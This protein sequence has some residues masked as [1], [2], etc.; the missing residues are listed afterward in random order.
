MCMHSSY[1]TPIYNI[2]ILEPSTRVPWFRLS[3]YL[4]SSRGIYLSR[5]GYE[6]MCAVLCHVLDRLEH[7]WLRLIRPHLSA[8]A[9]D[10]MSTCVVHLS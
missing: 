8:I 4:Y 6:D 3:T 2:Y 7:I 1:E 5:L 10:A 9:I